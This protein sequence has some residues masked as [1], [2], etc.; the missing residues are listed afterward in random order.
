MQKA[1]WEYNRIVKTAFVLQYTH[2]EIMRQNIENALDS[3]EGY[4]RLKKKVFYAKEGKFH[5]HSSVEQQIWSEC[6]RLV[7]NVIIYY[8]L[9][10]LSQ[11]LEQQ[12]QQGNHAAVE[13]LKKVSPIAWRHINI[14]GTYRFNSA[15]KTMKFDESIRAI[16]L[17]EILKNMPNNK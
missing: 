7:T 10:L 17:V 1:L 16:N 3:Q 6:A 2:D 5:V 12:Q 4:H 8:N 11:L 15:K 13:F 9:W 14:Y